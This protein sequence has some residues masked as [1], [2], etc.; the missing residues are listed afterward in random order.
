MFEEL[1]PSNFERECVEEICNKEELTEIYPSDLAKVEAEWFK[2][3]KA[4]YAFPCDARG[5]AKCTQ[6]WNKRICECKTS[7]D[8]SDSVGFPQG[9]GDQDRTLFL[10]SGETCQDQ[11]DVCSEYDWL[12]SCDQSLGLVCQ[13]KEASLEYPQGYAC[14]CKSG[15]EQKNGDASAQCTDIDECAAEVSICPDSRM[16]CVNSDGGYSCPCKEGYENVWDE[17]TNQ[18][19]CESLDK[20]AEVNC[21]ENQSCV[22][23]EGQAQCLCSEGFVKQV[24]G[25]MSGSCVDVDECMSG[26]WPC[27]EFQE[28]M[29]TFGSFTCEDCEVG[30]LCNAQN[31]EYCGEGFEAVEGNCVVICREGYEQHINEVGE[32]VCADIDECELD[33]CAEVANSACKNLDGSYTCECI[34]NS[35]KVLVEGVESCVEDPEP[36]T[37]GEV[38][39]GEGYYQEDD[40]CKDIDECLVVCLHG[41]ECVNTEGSFSCQCHEG[42]D[43]VGDECVDIDECSYVDNV[44][45]ENSKCHNTPGSYKC[46]CAGVYAMNAETNVCERMDDDWPLYGPEI[47]P[48]CHGVDHFYMFEDWQE[49]FSEDVDITEFLEEE[50]KE[51]VHVEH[52][53]EENSDYDVPEDYAENSGHASDRDYVDAVEVTYNDFDVTAPEPETNVTEVSEDYELS[54]HHDY[55]LT[56][57]ESTVDGSGDYEDWVSENSRSDSFES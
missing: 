2:L 14:L 53:E 55:D 5:T 21:G 23:M 18:E 48:V 35:H 47:H 29:N 49:H 50:M 57:D 30:V 13:N 12:H 7:E 42:F 34:G 4:C 39:C 28:C 15:Y 9:L 40:S 27:G 16:N 1:S 45:P 17:E 24:G 22:I 38:V 33:I 44:C 41:G 6:F 56:D 36:V 3:K 11:V 10:F 46:V 37:K 25:D 26:E 20:C 52:V 54:T 43:L 32:F 31:G 51:E 19:Y 8:F